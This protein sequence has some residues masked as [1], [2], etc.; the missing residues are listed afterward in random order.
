[1]EKAQRLPADLTGIPKRALGLYACR[2][3]DRP[4]SRLDF[5]TATVLAK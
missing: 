2:C 5:V 3:G 1:M 4:R